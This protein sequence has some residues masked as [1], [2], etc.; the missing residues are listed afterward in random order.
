MVPINISDNRIQLLATTFG[1]SKGTLPFTCLG[2]PLSITKPTDADFWPLVTKCERRLVNVSSFLS[3]A[4]R[5]EITNAVFSALPTFAMST[6][7]L[8]KTII[9]QIDKSRKH[10][11]W[12]GSDA[13][14]RKPPKAAWPLVCVPK[15]EGG[16]GVLNLQ[17]H[18]ECLLLKHL[19]KFFN[20]LDIPWVKLVWSRFYA[21]GRLPMPNS[22]LRSSFWWRDVLKQLDSFKGMAAPHV[23][24][25]KSCLFWLDLWDNQNLSQV[26]P[27]LYSFVKNAFISTHNVHSTELLYSLFHL[28]LLEVAYEQFQ[29]VE[30]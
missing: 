20:G 11:L 6:Y 16:L 14:I 8:L 9:K 30:C 27:E 4:G 3:Q 18:I 13:N 23:Q 7:L 10:C 17:T 24:D 22:N 26:Y 12:R 5:L 25:G 29:E 1:C 21:D 2:L 28:P 19:H 15:E